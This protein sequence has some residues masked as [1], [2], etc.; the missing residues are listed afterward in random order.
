[1]LNLGR[2][3]VIQEKAADESYT[4]GNEPFAAPS[5]NRLP[6]DQR[7]GRIDETN[8]NSCTYAGETT[9]EANHRSDGQSKIATKLVE[10]DRAP[11]TLFRFRP[12]HTVFRSSAHAAE[13]GIDDELR[14]TVAAQV[15]ADRRLGFGNRGMP[16]TTAVASGSV[17]LPM[18]IIQHWLPVRA[19]S[20]QRVGAHGKIPN[21]G[22]RTR[23]AKVKR[24]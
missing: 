6:I 23:R 22:T 9:D 11:R 17:S 4:G 8:S 18:L 2:F 5:L 20:S 21:L 16:G 12:W 10:V 13:R 7:I 14:S 3:P 24:P 19:F 15:V 1:V